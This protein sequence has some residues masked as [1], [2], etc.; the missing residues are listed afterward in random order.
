MIWIPK[1]KEWL[2]HP[3]APFWL[4]LF[5]SLLALGLYSSLAFH[6]NILYDESYQMALNRHSITGMVRLAVYDYHPP[7]YDIMLHIFTGIFGDSL[8][9]CRIFSVLSLVCLVILAFYPVR[10]IFGMKTS[11]IFSLFLLV[12]PCMFYSAL[13]IRMYGWA[14]FFTTAACVYGYLSVTRPEPKNLILLV[15]YS[16]CGMYTHIYSL[17]GIFFCYVILFFYTLPSGRRK[18]LPGILVCGCINGMLFLPWMFVQ[19][20]QA[21]NAIDNYW[22]NK[23]SVPECIDAIL[24]F[25]FGQHDVLRASRVCILFLLML[26]YI[27]W[28]IMSFFQFF[29]SV[30][31]TGHRLYII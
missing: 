14:A 6:N 3:R 21:G 1:G 7:L 4:A 28:K 20:K 9:V 17:I 11:V 24:T 31:S 26:A 16:F 18:R 22:V 15:F 27:V 25:I 5:F 10:R 19:L 29:M 23:L 8:A 2:K 30:C 13:E 12:F